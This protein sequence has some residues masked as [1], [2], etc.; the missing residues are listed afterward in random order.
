MWPI[1]SRLQVKKMANESAECGTV[2]KIDFR[3]LARGS[4]TE[5]EAALSRA[6]I[7]DERSCSL[8]LPEKRKKET[9]S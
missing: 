3:S 8:T 5:S 7:P 9:T 4:H 6:R 1:G 2:E